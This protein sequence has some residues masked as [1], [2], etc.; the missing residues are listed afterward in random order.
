[1]KQ[2]DVHYLSAIAKAPQALAHARDDHHAALMH[3]RVHRTMPAGRPASSAM[4]RVERRRSA[5]AYHTPRYDDDSVNDARARL[6]TVRTVHVNHP[7]VHARRRVCDSSSAATHARL[8]TRAGACGA[9]AA[10]PALLLIMRHHNAQARTAAAHDTIRPAPPQA[11]ASGG[12]DLAGPDPP[13]PDHGAARVAAPRCDALHPLPRQS[14]SQRAMKPAAALPH[15]PMRGRRPAAWPQAVAAFARDHR[16]GAPLSS[17]HVPAGARAQRS[18]STSSSV[19]A[20]ATCKSA[21]WGGRRRRRLP[22]EQEVSSSR[23]PTR[24]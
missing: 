1:M 16:P 18:T 17:S 10:A 4:M 2:K 15:H 6:D 8:D 3:T 23:S 19:R 5:G 20:R 12:P 11:G 7:A 22:A 21:Q 9:D 13:A 14:L 24:G